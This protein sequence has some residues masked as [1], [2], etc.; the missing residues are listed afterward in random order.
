MKITIEAKIYVH[1]R[2]RMAW[3]RKISNAS[4]KNLK[5]NNEVSPSEEKIEE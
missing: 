3:G 1:N 2:K 5:P 4:P